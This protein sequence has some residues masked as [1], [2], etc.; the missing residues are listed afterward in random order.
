MPPAIFSSL[1]TS[2]PRPSP[3]HS[4]PHP[5]TSLSSFQFWQFSRN[6][7]PSI[8]NEKRNKSLVLSTLQI[9]VRCHS[10]NPKTPSTSPSSHNCTFFSSKL[11]IQNNIQ[12]YYGHYKAVHNKTLKLKRKCPNKEMTK[13]IM[14]ETLGSEVRR[15]T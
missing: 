15:G 4:P 11:I 1:P 9:L 8:L 13:Q 7:L 6:N 10:M 3:P 5:A 14:A 2:L 12:I